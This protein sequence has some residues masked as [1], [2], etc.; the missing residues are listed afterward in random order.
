MSTF[1]DI[2]VENDITIKDMLVYNSLLE[3][4]FNNKGYYLKYTNGLLIQFGVVTYTATTNTT[5]TQ[6][7][8][9][10]ISF[11]DTGYRM[12]LTLTRNGT[13]AT[14]IYE[15]D[16]GGNVERQT[17]GCVTRINKTAGNYSVDANW[18][19]FGLWKVVS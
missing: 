13:V 14:G 10:P 3:F 19:C 6:T 17:W 7:V 12:F 11:I 9:F 1:K 4:N 18:I 15:C 8:S 2:N 5:Q 16:A